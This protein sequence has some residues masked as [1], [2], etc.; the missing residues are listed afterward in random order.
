M[1]SRYSV[2][3]Y[4][5][6]WVTVLLVAAMLVLGYAAVGAPDENMKD[7]LIGV[8]ISLGFFVFLF[9]AWRIAY[10]LYEGFPDATGKSKLERRVVYIVHRLLIFLLAV[11]II[12]GPLY[13]FTEGEGMNVFGW[14]TVYLPLESLSLIHEP[15]EEIHIITGLVILP[16]LLLVHFAGAVRHYKQGGRENISD[17]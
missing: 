12:T 2:I 11:Q 3:S 13:L 1:R 14:F 7:Y 9:V 4:F 10:R 17:M 8:H 6:H 16:L 5:N 15:A